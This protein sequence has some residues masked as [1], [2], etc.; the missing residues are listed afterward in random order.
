VCG[1]LEQ[2]RQLHAHLRGALNAGAAPAEISDTL[3]IVARHVDADAARRFNQLW[4]R[5]REQ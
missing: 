4:N 5:V 2:E 1:A 3:A